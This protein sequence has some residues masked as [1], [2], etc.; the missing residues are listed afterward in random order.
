MAQGWSR[1]GAR[2]KYAG[3]RGVSRGEAVQPVTTVRDT[4]EETYQPTDQPDSVRPGPSVQ[5]LPA[6]VAAPPAPVVLTQ[7]QGI[8]NPTASVVSLAH[9]QRVLICGH[10]YVHWAEHR[11]HRTPYGQHLGLAS[12]AK[13]E[14]RGSRGLRWD[15]LIPLLFCAGSGPPPEV[16][17]IHLGGNDLGLLQGRALFFQARED[18]KQIWGAWPHTHIIWSAIIPHLKW[19][20]GGDMQKLERARK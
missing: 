12:S 4:K 13:I 16:L 11:A 14:W 7:G 1:G 20:G 19:P 6:A 8:G 5:A 18:F 10:S 2:G 9:R 17:V 15:G 3:Q